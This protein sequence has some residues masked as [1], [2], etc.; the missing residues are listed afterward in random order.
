[1]KSII[2]LRVIKLKELN[3]LNINLNKNDELMNLYTLNIFCF[4][5]N[6]KFII[7]FNIFI[8]ILFD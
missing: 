4:V 2:V 6:E 8:I 5:L 7:G 3:K 1:M